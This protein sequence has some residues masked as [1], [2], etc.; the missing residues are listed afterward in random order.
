MHQRSRRQMAEGRITQVESFGFE[1]IPDASRYARPIDLFR[2]L[3]GGCNTFST[4]VLGSFPVLVGLSF[5]AGVCA[6]VLGV[7]AGTCILA[8]MS[9]FGPRNGT[10]D[11]VSSGAHFGIHG[12]IVG[13]FLALLTSIAFFSLAVWS[14]GD[15]LVGGAHDMVGVP[16]NGFTLGAAYMVFAVLVLIVCIYGF[17]FMLWVNKIAVWAA[18]VL[19]VAGLFA[20]AGLFDVNYAG[21]LHDGSAGFWAAFVGAVLVA[22]SN[23]V[24]F[25]STLGDWARYIPQHT[26]K[27]RVMGAVFAAQIA[28]FVPFFFGLATATII[29][30]KAPAFIASNDYVGG[31]LAISPRWFLLP[32]C[33]IAIIGGMS[34]GTTALYGTGLDVSS[35]FPRL[36][37]RVRATLLIGTIA[38]AFIFI[39]RFWFNLVESVSTFS[40][41]ICTFSCPWM[42]IMVIGYVTRRGYYLADDLQVFN[43]GLR[44]GHYW[45]AHGWNLRAMG[46]WLPAAFV[47][48]ACVNLP[49]QFVGPLGHLAGG[50]DLSVPVSFVVGAALYIVLLTLYPEPDGVYGQ[51]GRRFVRGGAASARS[52]GAPSIQPKGY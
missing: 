44:G 21:T 40:T 45:F 52:G 6:I 2:L 19:F 42:A 47:G 41:L 51:Q 35:M 33:L 11:P 9:L 24:S 39:G 17:R 4:S 38:I 26:P 23:P 29:A 36:L 7:L 1:R 34:T 49:G 27:R 25:A 22:L 31:L 50:L 3:F 15:A 48:L 8:P 10:S 28:T 32:M 5:K 12:R 18:S 16:V 20:F 46:A 43:R 13:S 14:S 30:S 37:T